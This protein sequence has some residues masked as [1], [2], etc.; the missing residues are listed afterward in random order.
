MDIILV[1]DVENLGFKDEVVTVKDGY[2]RNFLIPQGKAKLAT[3]SAKK[4]L[5]ENLRQRA[6]KEAK[7]IEDAKK[8][9]DQLQKNEVKMNAKA[10]KNGKLFGAI[11]TGHLADKLSDMGFEVDRRF[12]S[13]MGGSVKNVG[14]HTAKLRLHRDVSF[15][16]DFEVVGTEA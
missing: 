6:H 16:M 15:E 10:G 3:E 14:T 11:T 7:L 9:A 1:Q 5:A 12:I 13:I 8:M 2:G 4:V